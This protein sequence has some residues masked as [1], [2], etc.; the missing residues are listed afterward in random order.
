MALVFDALV[1]LAM[2]WLAWQGI[3]ARTLFRAVVSFMLFGLLMALA[4]V[5]LDATDLALAEAALGSGVTGALLFA[6]LGQLPAEPVRR[7]RRSGWY[8]R[9][10]RLGW[11]LGLVCLIALLLYG[12]LQLEGRGLSAEVNAA[13]SQGS[14]G[15]PVTA[16]LLNF[17]AID[18]LLELI[19]ML[20]AV[21]AVWSLGATAPPPMPRLPAPSLPALTRLLFPVFL[22][23]AGYLLWRGEQ[24]PGGAFPAGAVLAAGLVLAILSGAHPPAPDCHPS[25][26]LLHCLGP[27]VFALVAGGVLL[28]GY[29]YFEYPPRLASLLITGM[30]MAAGVSI[31]LM[32]MAL[33]FAAEPDDHAEP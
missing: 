23:T 6:A 1:A 2:L 5:R 4:W 28:A 33:F 3:H 14:I 8:R 27:L 12:T 15:S 26:R 17:R 16:V 13:L 20:S 31:G 21:V 25:W 10:T 11:G 22:L 18:T 9:F 29:V 19:V 32:L 30:E 24:G 7:R